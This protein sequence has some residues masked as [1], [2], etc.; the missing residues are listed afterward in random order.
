M[1]ECS[2]TRRQNIMPIF[3]DVTPAEVRYQI[4]SYEEAFLSHKEK[5]GANVSKWKAAL[6]HVANL[7]GWDNSK[8]NRGEGELVDEIVKKV[9]D[10]LKTVAS[11]VDNI[12]A[13]EREGPQD[14]P[15]PLHNA[16]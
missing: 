15:L 8:E 5:F 3:Y 16:F 6:N 4:G 2:K 9:M 14:G 11:K 12:M 1:V 13:W 7:N 10:E